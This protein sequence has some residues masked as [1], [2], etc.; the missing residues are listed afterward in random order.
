M[1]TNPTEIQGAW[2][3]GWALDTHI[4]SS[5][6][7]GYDQNGHAQFNNTRSDLGE[8]LYLLKYRGQSQMAAKIASVMA[9]FF[10]DKPNALARIEAIVPMP[11]STE[12]TTQPVVEVAKDLA[13]KLGKA[14]LLDTIEKTRET[15]ALKDIHDSE[16]RRELLDGAFKVDRA[17]ISGRG[18]LLIDDLYS[19]GA[20]ANAV[21]IALIG[22]GASAVYFLAATRTRNST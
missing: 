14:V 22:A 9:D 15:P 17:K 7:L 4:R 2:R 5:E 20:T 12:R 6:F 3:R 1:M 10:S 11:S 13:K 19:S 16:T 21:T 8:M 18:V